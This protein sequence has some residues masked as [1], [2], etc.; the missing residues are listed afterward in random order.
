MEGNLSSAPRE[1]GHHFEP[2]QCAQTLAAILQLGN[3]FENLFG[4]LSALTDTV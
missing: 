1:T 4:R 2:G 3:H